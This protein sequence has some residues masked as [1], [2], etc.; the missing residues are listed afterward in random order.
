MPGPELW[1]SHVFQATAWYDGELGSLFAR[2]E[3]IG[4]NFLPA[5]SFDDANRKGDA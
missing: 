3:A 2:R 5:R 4:H 1:V